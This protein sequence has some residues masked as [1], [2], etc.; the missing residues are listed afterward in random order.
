M[1]ASKKDAEK[2]AKEQKPL[3]AKLFKT[4][5]DENDLL[6]NEDKGKHFDP[7]ESDYISPFEQ[8]I[9]EALDIGKKIPPIDET[10][11]FLEKSQRIVLE[12]HREL[13]IKSEEIL[14]QERKYVTEKCEE[15]LA[16]TLAVEQIK[17]VKITPAKTENLITCKGHKSKKEFYW[18]KDGEKQEKEW[19]K[20]L[21]SDASLKT[22]G[23][24]INK[25]GVF[26][27]YLVVKE[28]THKDGIACDSSETKTQVIQ[29]VQEDVS[30]ET[31]QKET[32]EYLESQSHCQLV[33]SKYSSE[34]KRFL[35]FR[36]EK[37]ESLPCKKIRDRGGQIIDK[38][39][40]ETDP[41]GECT[42]HSKTYQLSIDLPT[43]T[44]H[45]SF[46]DEPIWGL[47][48]FDQTSE[49]D[50]DFG[51]A[52]ARL[53]AISDIPG[54]TEKTI[55]VLD[56]EVFPG[57]IATC[58]RSFSGNILYD[59]CGD[60]KGFALDIGLAGCTVEERELYK[61]RKAGKCHYIGTRSL[62]M[63]LEKESIYVC[64]PTIL[65]RIIQEN[66]REQLGL[67]WGDIEEPKI[68]GLKINQVKQI[69]FDRIDFSDFIV[70]LKADINQEDIAKKIRK[71]VATFDENRSKA[72][73]QSAF[74]E[75]VSLCK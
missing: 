74:K 4:M 19:T 63:G 68:N 64:F 10:E 1:D 66:G 29:E 72:A 62:K 24:S 8:H 57:K 27:D 40:I 73:T 28:W 22:W 26:K 65:A 11:S 43:R 67:S 59:C 70:R 14:P 60:C 49:L 36:C 6:P 35:I 32:L 41:E 33:G 20:G 23:V 50:P 71:G 18:K 48:E 42:T 56:A 30:W 52:I 21:I 5:I 3:I 46:D 13:K 34:D 58:K 44:K 38:T 75:Q 45:Y 9:V 39:C 51:D 31:P 25:G 17:K 69:N 47:N 53:A 54:N 7:G 55:D 37:G 12:P 2:V 15:S 16:R 61:K